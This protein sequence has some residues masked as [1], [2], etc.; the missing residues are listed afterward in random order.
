M[1]VR[2]SARAGEGLESRLQAPSGGRA[3]ELVKDEKDV[4]GYL[5]PAQGRDGALAG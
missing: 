1:N 2:R 3:C 4:D 5:F